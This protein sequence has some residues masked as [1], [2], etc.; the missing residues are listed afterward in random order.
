MSL[1]VEQLGLCLAEKGILES[2]IYATFSYALF[3]L[4]LILER[5]AQQHTTNMLPRIASAKGLRLGK[6]FYGRQIFKRS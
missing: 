2:R 4:F 3:I 6:E 5:R 1:P